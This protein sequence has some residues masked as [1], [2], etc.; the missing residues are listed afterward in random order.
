MRSVVYLAW[1]YL[2]YHRSKTAV[3]ALSIALIL[4]VPAGLRVLVEQSRR[5]LTARA[6]ATPLLIGAKGSPLELVLK[7]LYA[8]GETPPPMR[9]GEVA[10]VAASGLALPIPLYIRF[11]TQGDPIVGTTLDYLAFRGLRLAAGRRM[12]RLGECVAGAGVARRRGLKPGD[13]VGSS[14]ETLFDVAGAYP[15][16]MHVVGILAPTGTPDDQVIFADVKT[17]WVIEGLAHGHQ[18]L[19]RPE[20]A[21]GV[22]RREGAHVTAGA[23]LVEYN[24]VT[25]QNIGSFH[26]HGDVSSYPITA[27]LAVP[28]DEKAATL[29]MGRYQASGEMH[30]IVRPLAVIEKLL[31]TVLTVQNFVVATLAV[32]AAATLATAALVFLLSLRLRRR[33]M[34]TLL[35]IGASRR[36]IAAL[37]AS[38]IAGVVGLAAVLAGLLTWVTATSG[39]GLIRRLILH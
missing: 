30:Q 15:L 13:S 36:R 8:G 28:R 20:A 32:V 34:E 5:E 26:F 14:A 39:A 19:S 24:E 35:R 6:A 22:L 12:A 18:D 38:E 4:Y 31:G 16:K 1:R 7:A 29:L 9:Y 10:R 2:A 33:E 27:I 17:T 25:P 3:L 23:A 11:H 37:M 21:P